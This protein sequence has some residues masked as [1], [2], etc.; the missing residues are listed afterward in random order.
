MKLF[1]DVFSDEEILSD[2]YP[3]KEKYEGVIWEIKSRW[4]VK[5]DDNVDIGCGNAFGGA[6]EEEQAGGEEVVKVLDIVDTF[7]YEETSFDKA[8][9]GAY[10]KGY[11]KKILE[12][13]GK[14]KADRVDAFKNGGRDFFKWINAN[15]DD[16]SFY[17]PK[18]YDQ[19]NHI[20]IAYYDGEDIAPTF[21][22]VSDGLKFIKV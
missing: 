17:T 19:E 6:G 9:F 1:M 18:N 12:Y 11:M 7:G 13:L 21:C 20:M 3:M 4:I 2:S 14:N 5:G 15:F 16:L 22:F 10:F 8:G